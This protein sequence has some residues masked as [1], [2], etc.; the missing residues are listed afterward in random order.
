MEGSPSET[1]TPKAPTIV[2]NILSPSTEEVPKK[3]TF[4][5]IPISTTVRMLKERIQNTVAAQPPLHRQRLIYQGKVLASNETSLKDIF[6][7]EAINRS[8]PLSLHLVLS[9]PPTS[10]NPASSVSSTPNPAHQ[11][12]SRQ[13]WPQATIPQANNTTSS[14]PTT[15]QNQQATPQVAPNIQQGPGHLPPGPNLQPLLFPPPQ[16]PGQQGQAPMPPHLQNA[17]NSHLAAMNQQF[18]AHFA[19]QGHQQHFHQ[20]TPHTHL[21]AH[22]WQQQMYPQPSFQ[23]IIAQQQQARAAAGQHGLIQNPPVPSAEQNRQAANN[24]PGQALNPS[25]NTIVRENQG[26]NGESFRMVIQST[27]ISRPNSG[28]GQRPHSRTSSHTPQRSSTPANLGAHAPSNTAA[29]GT[30]TTDNP[31]DIPGPNF[32]APN[33]LAMFQQRLSAIEASLAGGTAPPQAVFDHARTYLDNMASQP[34]TL[35]QGLEAPLRTRLNNL[36]TQ[37]NNLRASLNSVLSQV[38]ANQQAVPGLTL[39]NNPQASPFSWNGRSQTGQ[40]LA[41]AGPPTNTTQAAPSDPTL[42]SNQQSAT[43]ESAQSSPPSE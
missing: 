7:Q 6:G 31:P 36:S 14:V 30:P 34:N 9:P 25:M 15:Q 37:A 26:P 43:Q 42:T 39:G 29:F 3:L 5:D 19:A 40:Q 20:G 38:L 11:P 10:Q 33:P 32:T 4:S 18:A 13:Q 1:I 23:Q 22:Q 35:P 24:T 2:L 12:Q 28:M 21:Q 17:L 16:M 27:S 41:Q 8:E